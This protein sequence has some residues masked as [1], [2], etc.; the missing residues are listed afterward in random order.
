VLLYAAGACF[1]LGRL[2]LGLLYV[3]S[4]RRQTQAERD[5]RFWPLLQEPRT[6]LGIRRPV[7][8]G[9]SER[10]G[11]PLQVG[12]F[13]PMAILPAGLLGRLDEHGFRAMAAHELARVRRWDYLVHLL[14]LV[15][16]A[17]HWFNPLAWLALHR[18]RET[19][20]HACDE[21]AVRLIGRNE[22]YTRALLDVLGEVRG[23]RTGW[24]LGMAFQ[25]ER[26]VER[27]LA[28][29]NAIPAGVGRW[30]GGVMAL[31]LS[32]GG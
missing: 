7:V 31:G 19:G 13:S 20:E 9:T 11:S 27:I 6:R 17:A 14:A 16:L 29:K 2:G 1:F 30:A 23:R 32:A 24:G 25:A 22:V 18:L 3:A 8:L 10:L 26:R 15:V 28:M 21:W 5:E 12:V 4:L